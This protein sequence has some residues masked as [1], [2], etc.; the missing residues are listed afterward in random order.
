MKNLFILGNGFDLAHG[1]PTSYED[2]RKY[3]YEEYDI[4][5]E[6]RP[7][8]HIETKTLPDGDEVFDEKEAVEF[9]VTLISE[10]ELNGDQWSDLENSMGKFD[11]EDYLEIQSSMFDLDDDKNLFRM[12][13][14]YEDNA[15]NYYKVV[16]ELKK[17]FFAWVKKID[18]REVT[19]R[20][21]FQKLIVPERDVFLVFNYT[22]II[23]EIYNVIDY[24]NIHG[25]Q[26][27]D[28]IIFGHGDEVEYYEGKYIGAA[29]YL[30]DIKEELKK[31]TK[32]IIEETHFFK[33][34]N[35]IERIYSYGFSFS[36]VDLP[37]IR[38]ICNQLNTGQIIWY[39]N[40]YE[41]NSKREE[42]KRKLRECGFEGEF[43]V[44]SG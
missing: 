38:E 27:S 4:S 5:S 32:K 43:S 25:D 34:L 17:L 36:E 9:L 1:L 37:Y 41:K 23:E 28:E 7:G 11:F 29:D 20:E 14:I 26:F 18:T 3:L 22:T 31:D 44:F 19:V 30:T 39:L 6:I 15:S 13:Y 24:Y 33:D 12:Q 35:S 8:I 2:F 21:N 40:K 10:T 42:Y 16:K